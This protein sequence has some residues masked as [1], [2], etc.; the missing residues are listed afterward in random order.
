MLSGEWLLIFD[1]DEVQVSGTSTR[2]KL[3][4]EQS[5][6]VIIKV[7][8]GKHWSGIGQQTYQPAEF[9]VWRKVSPRTGTNVRA[10]QVTTFPVQ[11][12]A[13]KTRVGVS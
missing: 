3:H 6:F 13:S 8:G 4:E 9:Q 2:G 12:G 10:E 1:K 5:A 7:P 11:A